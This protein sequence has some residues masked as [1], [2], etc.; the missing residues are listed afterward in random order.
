MTKA[1]AKFTVE[2]FSLFL[3]QLMEKKLVLVIKNLLTVQIMS[4]FRTLL[5]SSHFVNGEIFFVLS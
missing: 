1:V 5:V 2:C 4:A 3:S